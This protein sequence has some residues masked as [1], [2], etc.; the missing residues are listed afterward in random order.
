MNNS[1]NDGTQGPQKYL[2]K[3]LEDAKAAG[4]TSTYRPGSTH[5]ELH[6]TVIR[7]HVE[8]VEIKISAQSGENG[9]KQGE[10]QGGEHSTSMESPKWFQK[11]EEWVHISKKTVFLLG[12]AIGLLSFCRLRVAH[13]P[14]MAI[15]LLHPPS[16]RMGARIHRL[17]RQKDKA[18]TIR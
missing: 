15:L 7:S 18:H 10:K 5:D 14:L 13:I 4:A 11:I 9:M 1:S 12:G 8:Q 3:I 6:I 17:H 16:I 2:R